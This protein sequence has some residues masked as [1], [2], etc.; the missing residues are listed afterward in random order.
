M[1]GDDHGAQEH[2][3]KLLGLKRS[4]Q[5]GLMVFSISMAAT[6]LSTGR[7]TPP[8]FLCK[9]F[10]I[11]SFPHFN[12]PFQPPSH[13]SPPCTFPPSLT[14]LNLASAASGVGYSVVTTVPNTIVT[15]YHKV[16]QHLVPT[17]QHIN[18]DLKPS[19]QHPHPSD[20]CH[21]SPSISHPGPWSVLR[22]GNPGRRGG[23]YRHPRLRILPLSGPSRTLN[24]NSNFKHEKLIL[25][26]LTAR[27]ACPW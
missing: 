17:I 12:L 8:L 15:L 23:G 25:S 16:T 26:L 3:T 22:R 1:L 19:S 21:L 18:L 5:F 2:V 7:L 24:I 20:T 11:L 27:S 13:R 14:S 4:Y 9:S 10:P 6:V